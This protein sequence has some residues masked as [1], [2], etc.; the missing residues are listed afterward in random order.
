MRPFDS[1][2]AERLAQELS[3]S[4][5]IARLLV[6]RGISD[7]AEARSF[8]DPSQDLLHSPFLFSETEQAT[9]RISQAAKSGERVVIH[10]DYDVDGI[11]GTAILLQAM[12]Q[13]GIEADYFLPHRIED[14]YGLTMQ[15]VRELAGQ[16]RLMITVDCGTTSIEEINQARAKGMDVIV[17]DHHRPGQERPAAVAVLNPVCSGEEYP[18]AGLSG[19]GVAYKLACALRESLLGME[20]PEEE[21]LDL[22]ALG[23]VSDVVPLIDENRTIVSRALHR[24][25]LEQRVGIQALLQ[26]SSTDPRSMDASTIA[27]RIGPRINALGRLSDPRAAV[28]LLITQDASR[29]FEIASE[30]HRLNG[31]RQAVERQVMRDAHACVVREGLLQHDP[32]LLVIAGDR[33]HRGVLGIVAAKLLES[34]GRP[35]ILLSREDGLLRGSGRS[36]P[37]MDI[38][39][40]LEPVRSLLLSG[41]GH[42]SAVGLALEES[43]YEELRDRLIERARDL[44]G[45]HVEVPPLW[46]DAELPLEQVDERLLEELSVLAP[47]GEKNPTPVFLF[48]GDASHVG[49]QIVGN[50]HLRLTLSHPR[51]RVGAIGYSLGDRLAQLRLDR[52]EI[53]A[54]PFVATYR[55][56]REV[57]LRIVDIRSAPDRP[58]IEPAV[59]KDSSSKPPLDRER[60]GSIFRLIRS[61]AQNNVLSRT[62]LYQRSSEAGIPKEEVYLALIIFAELDL[63]RTRGDR[64]DLLPTTA[65]Q[66]LSQSVTFRRLTETQG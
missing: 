22:A 45:D 39:A 40:V 31:K 61:F 27:F 2:L 50:N 48:R 56:R 11:C 53:A 44:W 63:L 55:G 8:L 59:H 54:T 5:L 21:D 15:R 34:Y 29:A 24:L 16:Y 38:G 35:V 42:E 18:F 58:A 57:Q 13:L 33:W 52:L 60:L 43:R 10:G 30:M 36:L 46:I 12:W 14:G 47:H 4:P 23:T 17:T 19:S 20:T 62:L 3:L 1:D 32:P 64:I 9:E 49:G 65:K 51:G 6:Q 7:P 25:R 26:V 66:D 28:E 41:G 37:S